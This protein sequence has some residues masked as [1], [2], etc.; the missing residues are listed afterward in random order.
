MHGL[1][2]VATSSQ[3]PALTNVTP[4]PV[5][6]TVERAD[7]DRENLDLQTFFDLGRALSGATSTW[8]LGEVLWVHLSKHLPPCTFVFYGYDGANDAIVAVFKAGDGAAAVD[9]MS[10]P[11]GDRLS[12]WVAATAQTVM[13]SDA[14]LDLHERARERSL[15]RSALAVPI[16]SNGQTIGVLSFYAEAVNAFDDGHRRLVDAAGKAV[17]SSVPELR[18]DFTTEQVDDKSQNSTHVLQ[19]SNLL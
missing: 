11:L 7:E 18:S 8:Q 13:N 3:L 12:G 9:A 17:A 2:L 16:V 6:Q 15:L 5:R 14:R 19:N 4:A 1:G 10:I